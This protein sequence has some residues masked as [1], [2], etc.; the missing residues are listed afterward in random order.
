MT[1]E[2]IQWLKDH[3]FDRPD[4][5]QKI[6]AEEYDKN[7]FCLATDD[8]LKDVC[9]ARGPWLQLRRLRDKLKESTNVKES[10]DSQFHVHLAAT[11]SHPVTVNDEWSGKDTAEYKAVLEASENIIRT[12]LATPGSTSTLSTKFMQQNWIEIT[13]R[14]SA[15]ELVVCACA[16]I[17][18][19]ANEF[20]T[21]LG[22]LNDMAGMNIIVNKLKGKRVSVAKQL[23]SSEVRLDQSSD[24]SSFSTISFVMENQRTRR[25]RRHS[26]VDRTKSQSP[27]NRVTHGLAAGVVEGPPGGNLGGE[28]DEWDDGKG[29]E[30]G[31]GVEEESRCATVRKKY[32]L[33]RATPDATAEGSSKLSKQKHRW[34]RKSPKGTTSSSPAAADRAADD[35]RVAEGKLKG[36]GDSSVTEVEEYVG[37][38]EMEEWEDSSN[39]SGESHHSSD[40]DLSDDQ[41][42]E[43]QLFLEVG[44]IIRWKLHL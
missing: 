21:F 11:S 7:S 43:G 18:L 28:K 8:D 29:G 44:K 10:T 36:R 13:S 1:E 14:P 6:A 9:R 31:G 4:V 41:V 27:P 12:L 35:S 30:Q 37:V 20:K 42:T 26:P 23:G 17:E 3:E 32:R 39:T 34:G 16:K 2:L 33:N 24:G 5:F 19:K 40:M 15:K 22:M 25:K 38:R